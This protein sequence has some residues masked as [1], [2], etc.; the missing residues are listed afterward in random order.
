M[1]IKECC[2]NVSLSTVNIHHPTLVVLQKVL[3]K[4]RVFN[5]NGRIELGIFETNSFDLQNC[6]TYIVIY[7]S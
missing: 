6:R 3:G 5:Y 1:F 2:I 7:N 4:P